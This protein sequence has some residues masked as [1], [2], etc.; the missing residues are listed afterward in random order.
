[1]NVWLYSLLGGEM[2]DFSTQLLERI[3]DRLKAIADPMRLRILHA[4]QAG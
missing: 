4:L 3:A 1:M 2:S